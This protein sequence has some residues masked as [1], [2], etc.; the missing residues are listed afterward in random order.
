[1]T[2]HYVVTLIHYVL[3]LVFFGL[4]TSLAPLITLSVGLTHLCHSSAAL[5]DIMTN[6]EYGLF[7]LKVFENVSVH[8]DADFESL[9]ED[10]S[11][12][13]V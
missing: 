1:M 3:F 11:Q 6:F 10:R 8:L 7:V 2:K 5:Y 9:V 4:R 12:S 13:V